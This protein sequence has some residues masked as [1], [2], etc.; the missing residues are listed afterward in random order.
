[1]SDE[2]KNA[3]EKMQDVGKKLT[4]FLGGL[5]E[6][7]KNI[8][9]K[10][11]T[12]KAKQKVG[13]VKDMASEISAGKTETATTPREEISA[14]AAKELFQKAQ[15]S[16]EIPAIVNAELADLAAG[17]SI[18]FKVKTGLANDPSYFVL[19]N[20]TLLVFTRASD[21]FAAAVYPLSTI[22]AFSMNPPRNDTA[23][24]F[25]IITKAGEIKAVLNGAEMYFK[26]VFLYKKLRE[27]MK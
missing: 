12:E 23:G 20:K 10:D 16:D 7:A 26:A 3:E 21:Q 11:L 15:L 18:V 19:T 22:V 27:A 9:V 17:E 5:A 13:E 4:G 25:S 6:K 2:I 8:D 1:M 14:E 24:R